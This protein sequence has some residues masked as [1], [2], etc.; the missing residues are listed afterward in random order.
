MNDIMKK[1]IKIGRR[2]KHYSPDEIERLVDL[3]REL[4]DVALATDVMGVALRKTATLAY[5]DGGRSVLADYE[6]WAN[7]FCGLPDDDDRSP[8]KYM[9]DLWIEVQQLKG[10]QN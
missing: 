5:E 10:V 6:M 3:I 7:E 2:G 1:E 4:D 9:K 8:M